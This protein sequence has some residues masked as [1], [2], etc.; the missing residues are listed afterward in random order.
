M[1]DPK[2]LDQLVQDQISTLVTDQVLEVFA[3][4]SWLQPLEKKIV[5]HAQDHFLRKFSNASAVPEIVEAVKQGITELFTS[6]QIP[7]NYNTKEQRN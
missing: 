7:A 2:V 3:S 6:G 4:D 5:Q 1:L